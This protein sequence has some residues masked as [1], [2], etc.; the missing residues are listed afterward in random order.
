MQGLGLGFI[1]QQRPG[2]LWKERI[3]IVKFH[4]SLV[5][6]WSGLIKLRLRNP[7]KKIAFEMTPEAKPYW[8]AH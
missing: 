2:Y 7:S 1:T 8:P 3:G 4:E 5:I 6:G